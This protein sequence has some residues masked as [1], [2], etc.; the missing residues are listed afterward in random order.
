[1]LTN[2][3]MQK[4]G[5]RFVVFLFIATLISAACNTIFGPSIGDTPA[6]LEQKI[7]TLLNDHRR[8][9]GLGELV[10]NEIIAEQ[11]RLHSQDMASGKVPVGH[12]GFEGRVAVIAKTIP[13]QSAAEVAALVPSAEA[14]VNGWIGSAEHRPFVEGDFEWTGVGVVKGSSGNSLYATQIFIKQR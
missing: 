13:W 5:L 7:F 14:A 8:S 12:D 10:W 4:S 6:Q 1:M 2:S 3:P 11:A 9:I